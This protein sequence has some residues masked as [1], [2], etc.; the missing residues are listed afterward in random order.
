MTPRSWLFVPGDSPAK[1]AKALAGEADALILDLEDSVAPQAKPAARDAVAAFLATAPV[2]RPQLW[3]RINPL[4]TDFAW[5]DLQA[6]LSPALAGVVLPKS[7]SGAALAALDAFLEE[8]EARANL[9]LGKIGVLPI[10]T[11]TPASIFHLHSYA[12]VTPRLSGLTWG[13]E[14]LSAAI[15]ATS[16][17]DAE[18]LLTP[19][20]QLARSLCLAGAAAAQVAAIETVYPNFRDLAGL[21]AYLDRGRRDGFVGMMAIHPSQVAAINTAFTPTQDEIDHARKV[22][23]LFEAN[24]G[25]GALS[26]DGKM[27]DMP[28]LRQ[29]RACLQRFQDR[30]RA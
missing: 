3:V 13:A 4:D 25:V 28:H 27:I 14:D 9:P 8:M 16:A 17:R 30:A 12:G 24:P 11:E 2:T 19:L 23:D 22:V 26:L 20:Y 7:D 1:M 29:A 10:A 15:G 6:V 5:D 18:G 21:G